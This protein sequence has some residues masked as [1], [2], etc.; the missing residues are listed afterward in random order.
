MSDRQHDLNERHTVT[1]LDEDVLLR[2]EATVCRASLREEFWRRPP[3]DSELVQAL[4]RMVK[5]FWEHRKREVPQEELAH[6]PTTIATISVYDS[7]AGYEFDAVMGKLN[8]VGL[9]LVYGNGRLNLLDHARTRTLS[10]VIENPEAATAIL[11]LSKTDKAML[12]LLLLEVGQPLGRKGLW[13]GCRPKSASDE[14]RRLENEIE[15]LAAELDQVHGMTG[16]DWLKFADNYPN[17]VTNLFDSQFDIP[18][19]QV[20]DTRQQMEEAKR[21]LDTLGA[22]ERS[23]AVRADGPLPFGDGIEF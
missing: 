17:D 1:G 13:R 22:I 19:G 6:G 8:A 2:V 23:Q 15:Q 20:V 18:L 21:N 14:K 11:E 5:R 3:G 4:G 16:R 7:A 10:D 9:S 12:T